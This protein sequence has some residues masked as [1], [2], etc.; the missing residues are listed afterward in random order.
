MQRLASVFV[1]EGIAGNAAHLA[2]LERK[3]RHRTTD[4]I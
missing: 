1:A 3:H 2:I 4:K